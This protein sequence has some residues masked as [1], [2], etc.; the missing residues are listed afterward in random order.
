LRR[1][2][3]PGGRLRARTTAPNQQAPNQNTKKQNTSNKD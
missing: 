2:R 1:L 3:L